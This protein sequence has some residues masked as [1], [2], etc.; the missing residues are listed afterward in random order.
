MSTV[1]PTPPQDS[2]VARPCPACGYDLRGLAA[3][4]CPECGGRWRTDEVRPVG[5]VTWRRRLA[6]VGTTL[7]IVAGSLSTARSC[8]VA[9]W[10]LQQRYALGQGFASPRP[11]DLYD[12]AALLIVLAMVGW[13]FAWPACGCRVIATLAVG[14]AGLCWA[15]AV[16]IHHGQ[17]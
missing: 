6:P 5:Q 7:A 14:A 4:Q 17:F 8:S 13:A 15:L 2:R 9:A 16:L 11:A 12:V 10:D 3:L 1:S